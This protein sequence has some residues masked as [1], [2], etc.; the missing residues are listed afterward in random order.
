MITSKAALRVLRVR[1][2]LA[3]LSLALALG[4]GEALAEIKAFTST[5][6]ITIG[7]VAAPTKATP[8]PSAINVSGMGGFIHKVSVQLTGLTH[9]FPDD[10]DV[11]LVAPDGTQ[12]LLLSD[13]G[14]G[15]DVSNVTLVIDDDAANY[16]PDAALISSGT[17]KPT[18][19]GSP[20]NIPA[21]APA[22]SGN[23]ALSALDGI[24]PNGVWK[25]FVVDDNFGD[26]G[27]ITSWTLNIVSVVPAEQG[28]LVISEFRLRGPNGANDEFVEVQNTTDSGH[29]VQSVGS[30]TGYAV[31]ASDGVVRFVIPNGTVIPARGHYLGV[32][33]AS[34]GYSLGAYPAGNGTT[35]TGDATYTTEIPDNAGIALFRTSIPGD[36]T[37]ANRLDAAGSTTELKTLYKEGTGYGV[38]SPF[39]INC[40]LTRNLSGEG[41]RDT[42]NNVAD[43]FFSDT[44][45][46]FAGAGQHLGAPGPENLSSPVRRRS[47]PP[48]V[49]RLVDPG[50]AMTMPPNRVRDMASVPAQNSTYGTISL[51]RKFVNSTGVNITR[52]RFRVVDLSTFPSPSDIADLRPRTSA[53]TVAALS[54]GGGNVTVRG[55]TLEQAASQPN[56]GGLNSTFSATS[57]AVATPL[58]NNAAINVRFLFGIQQNGAFKLAL[59]P[60]TLPA[61]ATGIWIISGHTISGAGDVE[62]IAASTAIVKVQRFASNVNID[63]ICSPGV[64]YQLQRSLDLNSWTNLGST[65]AGT[66]LP[67]TYIHAAAAGPN[68]QFYRLKEVP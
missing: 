21:P 33:V 17:Y 20:D 57:V 37:L 59:I 11:L 49:R 2:F 50:V 65:I 31:A 41:T 24:S 7:D 5:S 43:F 54:G 52:L 19:I 67:L 44:N 1:P 58:A 40:S 60:E 62:A 13:V 68:K 22:I 12:A 30:S 6:G 66:G 29:T 27:S 15:S 34:P 51:S 26:S 53:D 32:N 56:G 61:A 42:G 23:T 4:T 63:H 47:G 16:L 28:Q 14:A 3:V 48:L 45:G 8:Y 64:L 38:V 36:F 46:T 9:T 55:S 25:L 39:A 35:A 18:N 10:V